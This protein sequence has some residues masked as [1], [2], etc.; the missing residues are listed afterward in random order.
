MVEDILIFDFIGKVE[1][2]IVVKVIKGG[3]YNGI[4]VIVQVLL[5]F[6]I[7]VFLKGDVKIKDIV[8]LY[9]FD[10]MLVGI[11]FIGKQFKDYLEYFVK[12]FKQVKK[13]VVVNLV[14]VSEGGDIQVDYQG[15]L[16]W[17]YNYDVV[18]GVMYFIDIF[19]LV[20]VCILG[21]LWQGRLVVYDQRFVL[22][23]NNYCM[24]GGGDY[25]YVIEV[26]VVW[27]EIFEICQ[28]FIDIVMV[29]KMID[30]KDFFDCN[31]FFI[32]IGEIWLSS[33]KLGDGGIFGG[34]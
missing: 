16:V 5:F 23:I 33:G 26:L 25:L 2:D 30:L 4:L 12:Y 10:N 27:D 32:M 29:M 20:G 8:G 13:G 19:W 31:W 21:L 28:L 17:D 22:V 11:L 14:L 6:C 24:S 1:V 9:V 7:V 3:I 15:K 34:F 18:I